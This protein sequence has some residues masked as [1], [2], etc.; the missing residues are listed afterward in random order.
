MSSAREEV[1]V[2]EIVRRAAL[3]AGT[4]TG[5]LSGLHKLQA[6]FGESCQ[7]SCHADGGSAASPP[8][9]GGSAATPGRRKLSACAQEEL[10]EANGDLARSFA[11][12]ETAWYFSEKPQDS[13]KFLAR[14]EDIADYC[15]G[16]ERRHADK[17]REDEER[18]KAE[19]LHGGRIA[20]RK[21]LCGN[22]QR[23]DPPSITNAY[24]EDRCK[25]DLRARLSQLPLEMAKATPTP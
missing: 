22:P 18:R 20:P 17:Q 9:G 3:H 2:R 23:H 6:T 8:T 25:M 14:V 24:V 19:L 13:A 21:Q 15:A 11:Q 16:A 12:V 10:Q 7:T 1:T 5:E 4:V